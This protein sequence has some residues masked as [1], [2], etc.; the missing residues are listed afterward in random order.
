MEPMLPGPLL[1]VTVIK[2]DLA[3]LPLS[4]WATKRVRLP[5]RG[6]LFFRGRKPRLQAPGWLLLSQAAGLP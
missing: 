1:V 6:L 5:P 3:L 2:R 4:W